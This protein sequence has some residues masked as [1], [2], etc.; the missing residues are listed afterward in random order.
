MYPDAPDA[1]AGTPQEV[2][3]AAAADLQFA[4]TEIAALFEDEMG[5]KVNLRDLEEF[6]GLVQIPCGTNPRHNWS[7]GVLLR[8]T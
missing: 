8:L 2:T 5:V 1:S 6:T 7:A 4:F 3:V